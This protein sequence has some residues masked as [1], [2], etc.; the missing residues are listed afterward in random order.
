MEIIVILSILLLAVRVI[1]RVKVFDEIKRSMQPNSDLSDR[2][3]ER[4]IPKPKLSPLQNMLDKSSQFVQKYPKN[5]DSLC[6]RGATLILLKRYDDALIDLNKAIEL[7]PNHAD[8]F[9]NLAVLQY[10]RS[11]V[12]QAI[13]NITSAINS[14]ANDAHYHLNRAMFYKTLGDTLKAE[15]DIETALDLNIK[16]VNAADKANQ[17]EHVVAENIIW[18]RQLAHLVFFKTEL[19]FVKYEHLEYLDSA[20]AV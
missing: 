1:F 5:A 20:A 14:D 11:N 15:A 4:Q 8:A 3:Y 2:K 6:N 13:S 16:L 17:R 19:I 9:N 7:Q 12:T 10:R 18:N